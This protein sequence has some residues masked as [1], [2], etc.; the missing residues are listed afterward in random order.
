VDADGIVAFCL[1]VVS[2]PFHL[3]GIGNGA[4]IGASF[5]AKY[6]LSPHYRDSLR[7]FVTI[8]GFCHVDTQ[9]AAILHS[10]VNV[11][12]SLPEGR[13]DLPISYFSR[14]LFSEDYL[15]KVE[16]N[17]ALNIYTAVSNPIT[18]DGRLR[19]CKGALCHKDHSAALPSV[20]I[21][22]IIIQS[23]EDM[24]VSA[25]NVDP[26]LASR[27]VSHVWSHQLNLHA[28]IDGSTLTRKSYDHLLQSLVR[29][30]GAFVM[31]IASGHEVRRR[32]RMMMIIMMIVMAMIMI[33][34][35]MTVTTIVRGVRGIGLVQPAIMMTMMIT[36]ITTLSQVRLEMKRPLTD[37]LDALAL[38]M[39]M[40]IM[41][42]YNAH[43][44]MMT[45]MTTTMMMLT[46]IFTLPQVRQEV[47]RPLT[48]ILDALAFPSPEAL[49]VPGLGP[50]PL[51]RLT[52]G[53]DLITQLRQ[54]E[55]KAAEKVMTIILVV[56]GSRG[57]ARA[58]TSPLPCGPGPGS[59]PQ[60]SGRYLDRYPLPLLSEGAPPDAH[61]VAAG[62]GRRA[63]PPA[64]AALPRLVNGENGT[65]SYNISKRQS[66]KRFKPPP[67]PSHPPQRPLHPDKRRPRARTSRTRTR[68]RTRSLP[69]W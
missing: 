66:T 46:M 51:L 27:H 29:P 34:I 4:A 39:M 5:L 55:Q 35:M 22:T 45:M 20:P 23:T 11:F 58:Y 41:M 61:R 14:F 40:M 13:P 68:T 32:R 15:R 28:P 10:S 6:A 47:K 37:I 3:I 36:R 30:D 48:D 33:I 24:L 9:L 44:M 62:K 43:N 65:K 63:E 21:P 25:A 16:P 53:E 26:F 69:L 18:L 67:P 64:P 49:G 38:M 8:N 7:S 57:D 54:Q 59:G 60:G 31:W 56:A 50:T 19:L 52:P 2:S 1:C 17:L 42:E 12:S